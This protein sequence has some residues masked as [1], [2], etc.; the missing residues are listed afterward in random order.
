MLRFTG[1]EAR[2]VLGVERD[3]QSRQL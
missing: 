1:R 3:T 2:P